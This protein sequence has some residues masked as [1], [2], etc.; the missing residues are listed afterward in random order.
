MC[1]WVRRACVGWVW[2][3]IWTDVTAVSRWEAS[4]KNSEPNHTSSRQHFSRI[5]PQTSQ[6]LSEIHPNL[7][8]NSDELCL[9]KLHLINRRFLMIHSFASFSIWWNIFPSCIYTDCTPGSFERTASILTKT[10][11]LTPV[12]GVYLDN[13][14]ARKMRQVRCV[15]CARSIKSQENY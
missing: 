3:H 14:P 10:C 11:T 4:K 1:V 9:D 2:V 13:V 8:P 15:K 6:I 7:S 12:T 5:L